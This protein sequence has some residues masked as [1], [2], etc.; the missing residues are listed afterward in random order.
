M[1]FKTTFLNI[2]KVVFSFIRVVEYEKKNI[3]FFS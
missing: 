3:C 2:Y 1:D